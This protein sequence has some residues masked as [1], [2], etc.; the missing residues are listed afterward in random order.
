MDIFSITSNW[1][2]KNGFELKS[3]EETTSTNDQA[4]KEAFRIEADKALYLASH[5]TKGRGRFDRTWTDT[6]HGEVLL[7]SW[8]FQVNQSPTPILPARTGL[9]VGQA[10]EKSFPDQLWS[11]KAPNDIFLKGKKVVG[12]LTEAVTQGHQ[13]RLILGLGLNV[14]SSP[15]NIPEA[16]SLK[17]EGLSLNEKI[18]ERFL[19]QLHQSF[20]LMLEKMTSTELSEEE[21][22]QLLHWLNR[23]P[24]LDKSYTKVEGRGSLHQGN[25][26]TSWSDL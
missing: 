6:G 26:I 24:H 14:L 20:Q 21:Q 25:H 18:W 19:D 4:K 15:Q 11:L 13:Y 23:N 7:S 3:F 5:Q 16:S 10:L 9:A 22:N 17:E 1:A 8:S 12:L 2:P